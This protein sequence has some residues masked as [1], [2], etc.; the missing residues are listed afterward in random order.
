MHHT[1]INYKIQIDV[2]ILSES[3]DYP[4]KYNIKNNDMKTF[5]FPLKK[6]ANASILT[7]YLA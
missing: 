5:I 4:E 6:Y 3:F 1:F 7:I 2:N